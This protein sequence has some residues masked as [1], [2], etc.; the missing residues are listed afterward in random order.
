MPRAVGVAL[1][2]LIAVS[3]S[4]LAVALFRYQDRVELIHNGLAAGTLGG[5]LLLL[6][7]L[8]WLPNL[9]LWSGSWALGAGMTLGLDSVVSPAANQL[10]I[11]PSIPVLGALPANGPGPLSALWWLAGGVLAGALAAFVAVRA[12]PRARFDETALVGGLAGVASG[13][14]FWALAAISGGDLGAV[15][16]VGVGARL[17]QLAVMAPTLLGLWGLVTGLVMGLVRRP[18]AT[19]ADPFAPTEETSDLSFR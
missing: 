8:A 10:G 3:A 1:S 9:I 7:Q 16:L 5:V 4:V 13:L 18:I 17:T 19:P 6:M 2:T 15:R 11:L 14:A 12:R